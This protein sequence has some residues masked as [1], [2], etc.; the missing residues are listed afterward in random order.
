MLMQ[1]HERLMANEKV[2]LLE[3]ELRLEETKLHHLEAQMQ[4]D[5]AGEK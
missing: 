4:A 1:E 2:R 5:Q 3:L